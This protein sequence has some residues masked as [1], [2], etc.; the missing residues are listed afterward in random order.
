M[1]RPLKVPVTAEEE[2]DI[3]LLVGELTKI[4]NDKIP[5]ILK[6]KRL[7]NLKR[8]EITIHA[9]SLQFGC[10]DEV[11]EELEARRKVRDGENLTY[12]G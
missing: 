8:F 6:K 11:A 5:M 7:N 12:F 1:K 9:V 2:E 4:C 10:S 3:K